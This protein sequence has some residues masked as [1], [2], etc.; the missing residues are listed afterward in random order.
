MVKV[1]DGKVVGQAE[2]GDY[3]KCDRCGRT[4]PAKYTH[5]VCKG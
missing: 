5:C 3:A 1:E 4:F 2:P